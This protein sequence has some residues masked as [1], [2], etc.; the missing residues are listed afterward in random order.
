MA[1]SSGDGDNTTTEEVAVPVMDIN[2]YLVKNP[3]DK[4]IGDML[5]VMYRGKIKT[6]ADWKTEIESVINRRVF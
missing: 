4:S 6:E 2:R 5:K 1:K 3:K